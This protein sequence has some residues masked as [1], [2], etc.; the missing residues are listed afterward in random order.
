MEIPEVSRLPE[1]QILAEK[2]FQ[3]K[4]LDEMLRTL[5]SLTYELSKSVSTTD[6]RRLLGIPTAAAPE[7]PGEALTL[8]R[9]NHQ[10]LFP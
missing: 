6:E 5:K 4:L 1:L 9:C 10:A 7:S 8:P 2:F 3:G